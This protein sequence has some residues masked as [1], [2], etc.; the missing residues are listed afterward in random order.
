MEFFHSHRQLYRRNVT[1][2]YFTTITDGYTDAFTDG[3]LTF[4]H[5]RMLDCLVGQHIY[6]WTW[7]IQ[8]VRALTHSYQR[9][10]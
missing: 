3:W 10:C 7:Q 6:L 8:C 1:R 4:Q 9:I 5:A 2:R